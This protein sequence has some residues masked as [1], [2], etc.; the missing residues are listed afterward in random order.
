MRLSFLIALLVVCLTSSLVY[1]DP[2]YSAKIGER[3]TKLTVGLNSVSLDKGLCAGVLPAE[4]VGWV[5]PGR[6]KNEDNAS[7][8]GFY[9]IIKGQ[10]QLVIMVTYDEQNKDEPS[11]VYAD[12]DG[13]GLITNVWDAADAPGAC[14]IMLQTALKILQ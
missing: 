10:H 6:E 3:L 1:A 12:M 2:F 5:I 13:K 11:T 9:M 4:R 8:V 7:V 14:Q